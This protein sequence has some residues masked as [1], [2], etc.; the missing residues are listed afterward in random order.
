MVATWAENITRRGHVA[1]HMPAINLP[2]QA[3]GECDGASQS[4]FKGNITS[5][6]LT[7]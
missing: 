3:S 6:I 2:Q 7:F 1:W 5:G 4:V